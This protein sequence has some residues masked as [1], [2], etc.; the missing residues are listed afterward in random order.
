[1]RDVNTEKV[2]A[3]PY[4]MPRSMPFL[5]PYPQTSLV[6]SI[7][8]PLL[9][10]QVDTIRSG[11]Q[12]TQYLSTNIRQFVLDSKLACEA[13]VHRGLRVGLTL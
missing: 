2:H 7:I 1:M 10:T 9:R 11:S 5:A 8:T 12:I 4:A 3:M 6:P 13:Q